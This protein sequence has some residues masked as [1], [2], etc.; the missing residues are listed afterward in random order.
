MKFHEIFTK[1]WDE[2]YKELL[3]RLTPEILKKAK[4]LGGNICTL[5]ELNDLVYD[6]CQVFQ[7]YQEWFN[8]YTIIDPNTKQKI[9]L[10][11]LTQKYKTITNA[12]YW[13]GVLIKK[14]FATN[15]QL[16]N[17]LQ[18]EDQK[19][20]NFPPVNVD[21]I[22]INQQPLDPNVFK[23]DFFKDAG[24]TNMSH[25]FRNDILTLGIRKLANNKQFHITINSMPYLN[26]SNVFNSI[27]YYWS[28]VLTFSVVLIELVHK[29]KEWF[30]L[31]K[32]SNSNSF[33]FSVEIQ[34][35]V[36]GVP[37]TDMD[38]IL[39]DSNKKYV[40]Q[41]SF[42][43]NDLTLVLNFAIINNQL[44]YY[45]GNNSSPYA[46]LTSYALLTCVGGCF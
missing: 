37:P 43:T 14:S 1:I 17:Y 31:K 16:E 32:H 20:A 36:V 40:Q 25:D 44:L 22:V 5:Q 23:K 15:V 27:P 13:P 45:E 11:I 46:V 9:F 35:R 19:L 3:K 7:K 30:L 29:L 2:Y 6:L 18:T 39:F 28:Q 21:L 4:Q 42:T 26:H 8:T 33:E 10:P 41:G 24:L 38:I 34:G 12:H